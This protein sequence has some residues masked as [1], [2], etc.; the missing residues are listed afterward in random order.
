MQK[1]LCLGIL[2][3]AVACFAPRAEA[4]VSIGIGLPGVSVYSGGYGHRGVYGYPAY[5]GY[6]APYPAYV[7]PGPRYVAPYGYPY[8]YPHH[9]VVPAPVI[10][11]PVY[12]GVGVRV[13]PRPYYHGY[14][15][16]R[17]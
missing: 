17:Y 4:Q 14:G 7:A 9:Y 8:P 10:P 15:A 2:A 3:G 13:A 12:G 11:P 16:Y 6:G 5:G 1:V